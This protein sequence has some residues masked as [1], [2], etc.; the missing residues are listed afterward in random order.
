MSKAKQTKLKVVVLQKGEKLPSGDAWIIDGRYSDLKHLI[1]ILADGFDP[2]AEREGRNYSTQTAILIQN[3]LI[4]RKR[5]IV[6]S[7]GS[8]LYQLNTADKAM[9]IE[10]GSNKMGY[11]SRPELI[12]SKKAITHSVKKK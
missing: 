9:A 5:A 11:Y 8:I 12:E 7:I 6:P 3:K 2:A 1:H 10:R 4:E